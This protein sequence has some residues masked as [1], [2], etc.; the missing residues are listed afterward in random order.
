V[1]V[2]LDSGVF[3]DYLI[4]P[5]HVGAALRAT[6]RRG[7]TPERLLEDAAKCLEAILV[8]HAGMTS[9]LMGYEV[10][11]ALYGALRD[12]GSSHSRAIPAARAVVIQALATAQV[13][14]IRLL[15]LTPKI[16]MAQC[17]NVE[18]KDRRIRAADALH[19]ATALAEGADLFITTDSRLIK[20]DNIFAGA[21]GHRLRCV[22]TDRAL[23]LLDA[24]TS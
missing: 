4:D 3:I 23:V 24:V 6:D 22:D 19:V 7:R 1:K 9:S 20:L 21:S 11:E 17:A 15:D 14:R 16:V 12:S 2:Y 13:F 8:R 5:G 18:L 10:E